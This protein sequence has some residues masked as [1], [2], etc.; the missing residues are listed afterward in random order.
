[1]DY[2]V[3]ILCRGTATAPLQCAAAVFSASL[4]HPLKSLIPG[5][6]GMSARTVRMSGINCRG[7]LWAGSPEGNEN[8]IGF[9]QGEMIGGV[10]H[11]V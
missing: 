11:S 5:K 6:S 7:P 8:A 10:I 2:I 4:S 1:M 3:Q 9:G